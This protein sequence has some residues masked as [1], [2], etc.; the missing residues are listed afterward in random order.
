MFL[1]FVLQLL[2]KVKMGKGEI[3][4]IGSILVLFLF[5]FQTRTTIIWLLNPTF[6]N[7]YSPKKET[8]HVKKNNLLQIF[9]INLNT[10][11]SYTL[12]CNHWLF[13]R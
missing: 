2:F 8:Q 1:L 5:L 7:I 13:R 12:H 9:N 11:I 6:Y 10:E 3:S 4:L